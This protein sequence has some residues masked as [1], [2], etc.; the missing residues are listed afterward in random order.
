VE[1]LKR[2]E[3]DKSLAVFAG[4]FVPL[5]LITDGNPEWSKWARQYPVDGNGIP[6]LYVIRADGEKLYGAVGALAGDA[7]PRMLYTTLQRSGRSF[8]DAETALLKSSVEAA[9]KAMAAE[10]DGKAA[11]ELSKLAR[12]GTVGD[13]RSYSTPALKADEIAETLI[14]AS[15]SMIKDAVAKLDNTET[16]FSGALALADAERQYAGFGTIQSKISATVRPRNV[17][18]TLART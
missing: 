10:N 17:T 14:K 9:E 16:V 11:A 12:L 2:L 18:R 4:Q 1:L 5:K 8:N 6:R 7:L 3:T 15:D 13:F